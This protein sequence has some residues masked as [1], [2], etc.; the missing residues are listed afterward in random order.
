MS[1]LKG[2][3]QDSTD[4]RDVI[5]HF[6]LCDCGALLHSVDWAGDWRTLRQMGDDGLGFSALGGFDLDGDA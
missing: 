3:R 2:K 4:F 6:G 5:W 1:E